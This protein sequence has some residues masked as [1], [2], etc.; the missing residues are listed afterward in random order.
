MIKTSKTYALKDNLLVLLDIDREYSI[1]ANE[2][3]SI[4]YI[5]GHPVPPRLSFPPGVTR[6][7]GTKLAILT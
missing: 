5:S 6:N 7:F 4:N 3:I 2:A 1:P